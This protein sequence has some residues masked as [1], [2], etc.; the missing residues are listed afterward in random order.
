MFYINCPAVERLW[1]LFSFFDTH[2]VLYTHFI[3]NVR[4]FT[5]LKQRVPARF[6]I[7]CGF[8]IIEIR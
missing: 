3:Q 4:V 2:I 1:I 8:A 6:P 5:E 7:F